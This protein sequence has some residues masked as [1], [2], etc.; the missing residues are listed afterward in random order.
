MY[1]CIW[2]GTTSWRAEY[3]RQ[4]EEIADPLLG[5]AGVGLMYHLS[6]LEL[7]I[8]VVTSKEVQ[9]MHLVVFP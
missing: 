8:P 6:E 1:G 2:A 7:Y 5:S 4:Q 9:Y 3:N